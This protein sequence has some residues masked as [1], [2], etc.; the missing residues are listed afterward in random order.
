MTR[1]VA[2]A[3]VPSGPLDRQP[4]PRGTRVA[5]VALAALLSLVSASTA[6]E[7]PAAKVSAAEVSRQIDALIEKRWNDAGVEAAS[8]ADDATFLRR[9][10]LDLTGI[11]PEVG[12]VRTFLADQR[13][14][15]RERIVDELLARPRHA[16]HLA[17]L[18]RD[19]LLPRSIPE[20]TSLAFQNWMQTRFRAGVAY[21]EFVREILLAN[22][23][24]GKAPQLLYFAALNTKP[25]ELAASSSRVFLGVQ[26]RCAE[27][28]DHP[29]AAWKQDDF[30][31]FAAFFSRVRGPSEMGG[32]ADVADVSSGEVQNPTTKKTVAPRLLGADKPFTPMASAKQEPRRSQVVAWM[33]DSHNPY[34]AR[35]AVNRVWSILMGRGLV[36]PVDNLDEN[37]PATH[38]EVLDLLASDFVAS[39]YDLRRVFRIVA[40]TRVYQLASSTD[41]TPERLAQYAVMPVRSLSSKQ[42]Y[43]CLVQ[44][45]GRRDVAAS[46][47]ARGLEQRLEFLR[48]IDAPTREA[49]EFQGGIPQTLTM[50]NGPFVTE[51]TSPWSSD[52]VAALA[53][54][55]YLTD[56]ERI[57]T[58]F[59]ATLTQVPTSP[60][61]AKWKDWVAR[62]TKE[63]DAAQPLSD[64]LW[65][66][67]NSSEFVLNR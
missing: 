12:E 21:D 64:L 6:D 9:L 56:D 31:G 8:Q 49:T 43:D 48:Q 59:L 37:N 4:C 26:I 50:L 63:N 46:G 55:P 61:R 20:S 36:H 52:I 24:L 67:V 30:W 1:T 14:D 32:G 57:D 23:S 27:C 17:N 39:G 29:F 7:A 5:A 19:V 2:H 65:G 60:Q 28:H 18:W 54:S 40:G 58:L 11:I 15:K 41:A 53:D 35:A 44:A 51:L 38:P 33:T 34:F 16:T 3:R 13:P 22:G 42:I 62:H 47:A 25:S 45:T 66:L 10:S